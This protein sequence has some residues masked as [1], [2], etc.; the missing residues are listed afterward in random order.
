MIIKCPNCGS[1][2]QMKRYG[3]AE[4][5]STVVEFYQCSCGAKLQRFLKRTKDV[6]WSPTGRMIFRI[7]YGG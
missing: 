1:T 3:S 2:A 4:S 7:K 6:G 5:E